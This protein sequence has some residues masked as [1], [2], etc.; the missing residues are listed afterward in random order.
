MI[1]LPLVAVWLLIAAGVLMLFH[2]E[3]RARKKQA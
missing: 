3:R 2:F 1:T